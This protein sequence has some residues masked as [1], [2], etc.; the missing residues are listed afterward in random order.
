MMG[1]YES[2]PSKL[3]LS[4][5]IR[6][7]IPHPLLA[8]IWAFDNGFQYKS[9]FSPRPLLDASS[10]TKRGADTGISSNACDLSEE[11]QLH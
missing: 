6:V 9:L 1:Y 4:A 2:R 3:I 7:F 10:K 11:F 8:T 5:D